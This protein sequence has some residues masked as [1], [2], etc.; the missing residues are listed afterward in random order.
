MAI[1]LN[2]DFNLV[3]ELSSAPEQETAKYENSYLQSEQFV[4]S[5]L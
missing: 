2:S 3:S 5:L 1:Q 4:A